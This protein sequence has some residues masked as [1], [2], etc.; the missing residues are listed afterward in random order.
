MQEYNSP[1][2]DSSDNFN[3]YRK[4]R[5][6]QAKT[7]R[8]FGLGIVI[9]IIG[10]AILLKQLGFYWLF[11]M[12]DIWPFVLIGI[13]LILGLKNK[14]SSVGPIVMIIIGT[15]FA[16]PTFSFEIGQTIVYS[17]KLVAPLIL[18]AVGIYF[19]F[20]KKKNTPC[21]ANTVHIR[22]ENSLK[23]EVMFGGIKEVVT[24]KNFTG[25]DISAIFG[26]IEVNLAQADT[27]AEIISINMNA[28]FGGCELI[29][30]SHWEVK[31]DMFVA[32]GSVDDK[33]VLRM[34]DP[35]TKKVTLLLKGV[36]A[37]GGVE[38][39]SY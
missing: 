32:L 29:V 18:I 11:P 16:I 1:V 38:I 39:K 6:E 15:A 34:Q 10:V 4:K 30:P 3:D 12:R 25:G 31:N 36:C 27:Q 22:D 23:S 2:N 37:F 33:R 8:R 9:L 19:L 26:G 5:F 28:I 24:S 35:N 7:Q 17:S 13:G 21:H 20:V 14:F